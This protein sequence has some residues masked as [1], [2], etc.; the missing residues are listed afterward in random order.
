M[1]NYI[2]KIMRKIAEDSKKKTK[3]PIRLL[4]RNTFLFFLNEGNILFRYTNIEIYT[5]EEE[6]LQMKCLDSYK[7]KEKNTRSK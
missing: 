2:P 1:S 3:T 6:L 5:P 4:F 7:V